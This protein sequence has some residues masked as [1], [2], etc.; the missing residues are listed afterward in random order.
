[1]QWTQLA[2]PSRICPKKHMVSN[3]VEKVSEIG[4]GLVPSTMILP[5]VIASA[6]F[7]ENIDGT[8]L[9]T[10]L[11]AIAA[12]LHVDPIILKLTFTSYLLSLAIF[13][14]ISGWIADHFGAQKVFCTAIVVF[15]F[16]SMCCAFTDTL[17]GFVAARFLQGIGGAMMMPVGRLVL[18]RSVPKHQ[19]VTALS[20]LTL[21]ALIGPV[22]GPVIGGF[23]TTFW[24]WRWIFFINV[25]IGLV[26]LVLA[27]IYVPDIKLDRTVPLDIKGFLL[28]GCGLAF[29]VGGFTVLGVEVL[30]IPAASAF[31][32]TGTF[33]L[34]AYQR[35]A[36][37]IPAPIL[38]LRLMSYPTFRTSMLGGLWFRIGSG[39]IPFLLPLMLQLGFGL[40][41]FE[42]G[43]LTFAS[44]VGALLM[45]I[46]APRILKAFGFRTILMVNALLSALFFALIA[47]FTPET[48]HG[49]IFVTLFIGGFFRSLQFTCL[50]AIAF[51]EVSQQEL[52]G[53]SSFA[54]V[55]QQVSG[56]I[57]VAVAALILESLRAIHH[58]DT[59]TVGDFHIAFGLISL[60]LATS[61]LFHAMLPRHAG[62]EVSGHNHSGR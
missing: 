17:A 4:R 28:S 11:P 58:D 26:G 56:S 35:H 34:W 15:T 36:R 40:S 50:N 6:L 52:S 24:Q 47:L 13:I 55:V 12:D 45:K 46:T 8:V 51:A 23:I 20:Y 25:P 14:P 57:G 27:L 62:S 39:S 33:L 5:L 10:S 30:S 54:S 19:L 1:M 61:L 60:V 3:G 49:L 43:L 48:S 38:D 59:L 16:A 29:L 18:V 22:I 7:L 41:A 9:A 37:R 32:A 53:A 21:P 44:A 2:S 42:T 31:I